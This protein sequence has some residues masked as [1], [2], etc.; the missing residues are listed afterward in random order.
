M[1]TASHNPADYN[2]LKLVRE[3]ARPISADTGLAD[4]RKLAE[5]DERRVEDGGD[6]TPVNILAEYIDHM[7]DYGSAEGQNA[8]KPVCLLSGV[9]SR[10]V[11]FFSAIFL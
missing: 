6:R 4:I 2:G 8:C 10:E 11:S 1:V 9:R 3:E 7:L 5:S